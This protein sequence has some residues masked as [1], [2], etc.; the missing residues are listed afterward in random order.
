MK[1][2]SPTFRSSPGSKGTFES[3]RP[4]LMPRAGLET[5]RLNQPAR[6][7]SANPFGEESGTSRGSS[8]TRRQPRDPRGRLGLPVRGA[9]AVLPPRP[10]DVTR[11]TTPPTPRLCNSALPR[12]PIAPVI[13][14]LL[15]ETSVYVASLKPRLRRRGNFRG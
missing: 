12:L 9:G 3:E 10:L 2:V 14:M 5:G 13:S 7:D 4:E 1:L 15:W 8:E 11:Y 6:A